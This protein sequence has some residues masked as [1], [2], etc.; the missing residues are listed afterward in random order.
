[1][2]RLSPEMQA[3]RLDTMILTEHNAGIIKA[4][5][6]LAAKPARFLTMLGPNGR[7]KTHMAA[8][9]VNAA[10]EHGHSGLYLTTADFLD[11]LKETFHPKAESAYSQVFSTAMTATVLV[12]DEFDRYAPSPWAKEK[13][14]QL[15]EHR[16]RNGEA[17]LTVFVSNAEIDDVD[18]YIRSRMQDARSL[19][20]RVSG[21]DMRGL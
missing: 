17:L 6:G 2:S 14:F 15:I 7:G 8:A 5:S 21:P 18:P 9:L 10:V 19:L 1:M 12:L 11:D 20:F 3:L 4:L 16:W 13:V